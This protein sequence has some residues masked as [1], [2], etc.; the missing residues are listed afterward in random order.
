AAR[1]PDA[2]SAQVTASSSACNRSTRERNRCAGVFPVETGGK[3][4][5]ED[6]L[7]A[8]MVGSA[9]EI[10]PIYLDDRLPEEYVVVCAGDD[11]EQSFLLRKLGPSIECPQCGRTAPSALWLDAYCERAKPASRD[12]R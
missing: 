10:A 11:E 5:V 2:K 4:T 12:G 8:R 7:M 6:T 1:A 3:N 9:S